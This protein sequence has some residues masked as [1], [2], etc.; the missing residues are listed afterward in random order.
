MESS[1][2]CSS[3]W[4]STVENDKLGAL[5]GKDLI[6]AMKLKIDFDEDRVDSELL[7]VKS[8]PLE[9][10]RVGHYKLELLN[11]TWNGPEAVIREWKAVGLDGVCQIPPSSDNQVMYSQAVEPKPSVCRAPSLSVSV[12]DGARRRASGNRSCE[13]VSKVESHVPKAS[14]KGKMALLWNLIV[15][16]TAAAT[17][18]FPDTVALHKQPSC[19]PPAAGTSDCLATSVCRTHP[20][21][22]PHGNLTSLFGNLSCCGDRD[23]QAGETRLGK[24]KVGGGNRRCERDR[25]LEPP[26]VSSKPW[27]RS[28][29]RNAEHE[30]RVDESCGSPSLVDRR[31]VGR[32][33]DT[34]PRGL[35]R[36]ADNNGGSGQIPTR[37]SKLLEQFAGLI[38]S[39]K[40]PMGVMPKSQLP[41]KQPLPG[42]S[43]LGFPTWGPPPPGMRQQVDVVVTNVPGTPTEQSALS[44]EDYYLMS[45]DELMDTQ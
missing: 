3:I 34:L 1:F 40:P 32:A 30:G 33:K 7:G 8:Q 39:Q 38:A 13:N 5:I 24:S 23:H 37:S 19:L 45:P 11:G 41:P 36:V 14:R 21:T 35:C 20:P 17:Q 44:E 2:A 18:V 27:N 6:K 4:Q 9:E 22:R 28:Q 26:D 10:T 15:A 31:N 16:G 12:T 43:G 25:P 42:T 29:R